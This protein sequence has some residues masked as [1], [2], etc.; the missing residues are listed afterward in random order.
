[1]DYCESTKGGRQ[2]AIQGSDGALPNHQK[3][4]SHFNCPLV[5][6]VIINWNYAKYVGAA[7]ASVKR[8]DYPRLEC[9][10]VD[11][12]SSDDSV[13][14]ITQAIAGDDRFRLL[15]MSENYGHLGAALQILGALKGQFVNFLDADDVLFDNFLSFHIQAHLVSNAPVGFTSS[16]VISIDAND[17]VVSGCCYSLSDDLRSTLRKCLP[18]RRLPALA[19]ISDEQYELLRDVALDAPP[20][21]GWWIWSPGSAN[22]IRCEMLR[23]IA[24]DLKTPMLGGI[25]GFFLTPLFALSGAC[26]IKAPLSAY[27][28]HGANDHAQLPQLRGL[29]AGN[30]GAYARNTA[31]KTLGLV[32]LLERSEAI[33]RIAQPPLKY[34]RVIEIVASSL[35]EAVLPRA[36]VFSWPPI[37]QAMGK[38]YPSLVT[39]FGERHTIRQLRRMMKLRHLLTVLR[40]AYHGRL[41]LATLRRL[42][43]E[44]VR[45]RRRSR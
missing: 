39:I 36:S 19:S 31:A 33:I 20:E 7:I 18:E 22:V 11:N 10:V 38:A 28:I 41:P 15:Q 32:T 8:Q 27:R 9:I 21:I 26:L 24:P 29:R 25:D 3:I 16:D 35:H 45:A 13:A 6:V 34:F 30:E 40:V 37:A 1:V 44:T 12:A 5:S 2:T 42:W 14:A 4:A 43:S 23:L 17:D